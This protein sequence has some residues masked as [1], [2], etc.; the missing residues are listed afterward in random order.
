MAD[1]VKRF[2]CRP[3]HDVWVADLKQSVRSPKQVMFVADSVKQSACSPKHV[4]FV[5]D[6]ETICMQP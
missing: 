6:S 1:S 3:G 5:A 2:A 4:M